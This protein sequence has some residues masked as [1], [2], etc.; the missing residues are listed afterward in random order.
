MPKESW[1]QESVLLPRF[2]GIALW[3]GQFLPTNIG[4]SFKF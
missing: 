1:W 2:E 3:L 4:S